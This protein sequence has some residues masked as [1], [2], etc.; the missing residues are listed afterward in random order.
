M[1]GEAA[2]YGLSVMV[3]A[4]S[5]RD[6]YTSTCLDFHLNLDIVAIHRVKELMQNLSLSLS[7][8]PSLPPP[9][10]LSKYASQIKMNNCLKVQF[11]P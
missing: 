8:L 11:M 10:S 3:S 9:L 5:V 4:C 6:L 1:L 2:D 7:L